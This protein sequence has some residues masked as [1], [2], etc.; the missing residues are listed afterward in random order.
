M[1]RRKDNSKNTE[2]LR[3][4]ISTDLKQQC[5]EARLAGAHGRMAESAFVGYLIEIGLKKYE[6]TI[7]PME[8]G[9]DEA[10]TPT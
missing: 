7:L 2:I 6:K 8:R 1:P 3:I 10:A 4:R 5:N 9:D